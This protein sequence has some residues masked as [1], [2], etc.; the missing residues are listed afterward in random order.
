MYVTVT[1]EI[2]DNLALLKKEEIV[3]CEI[4]N[5]QMKGLIKAW[6]PTTVITNNNVIIRTKLSQKMIEKLTT[7]HKYLPEEGYLKQR[8]LNTN[9]NNNL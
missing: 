2:L 5:A 7:L 6:Y 9:N 8:I 4:E 3:Y 1:Q